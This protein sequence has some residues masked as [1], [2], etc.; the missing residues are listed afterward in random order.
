MSAWGE[1]FEFNANR[2]S[3]ARRNSIQRRIVGCRLGSGMSSQ[4]NVQERHAQLPRAT[5]AG[6]GV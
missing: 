1:I 2:Q 6:S 3:V 4:N 5:G